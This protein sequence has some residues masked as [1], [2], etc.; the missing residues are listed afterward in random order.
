MLSLKD[1]LQDQVDPR[2][3]ELRKTCLLYIQEVEELK[4]EYQCLDQ[5][6][7]QSDKSYQEDNSY[8]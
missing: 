5:R 1:D 6:E 4:A 2:I 7:K 8:D 3:I